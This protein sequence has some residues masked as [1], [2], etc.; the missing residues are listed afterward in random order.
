MNVIGDKVYLHAAGFYMTA[1]PTLEEFQEMSEEQ[2]EQWIAE[3]ITEQYEYCDVDSIGAMIA[4]L[5]NHIA[6]FVTSELQ[7]DVIY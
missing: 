2:W 3:H 4:E 6:Y 7:V 1:I 5:S